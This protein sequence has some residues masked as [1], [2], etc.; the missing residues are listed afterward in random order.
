MRISALWEQA[1]DVGTRV[2]LRE[3]KTLYQRGE[4]PDHFYR[5]RSGF[6][7]ASVN[8]SDGSTLLLEIFGPG[9]IFGE[10]P[11]FSNTPRTATITTLTAAE[12]VCYTTSCLA[13][14]SQSSHQL[15][16]SLIE[17]L[18][19]KNYV[20]V[21]KLARF[22]SGRPFERLV[23]LLGRIAATDRSAANRAV[24]VSLT[25]E[26]LAAMSGL[27]RVTVTRTLKSMA[28]EGLLSTHPN[29]VRILDKEAM[30]RLMDRD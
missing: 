25:H 5:V 9:A 22:A 24:D 21:N 18:G 13:A 30:I 1:S 17:L 23:D 16:L 26:Q 12:L 2:K 27:S 14:N 29:Y 28:T 6:V 4:Q 10:G 19:V 20:L 8:R 15:A 3:G 7:A 11:A